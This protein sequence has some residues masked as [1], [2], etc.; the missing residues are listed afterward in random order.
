MK[1]H[2]GALEERTFDLHGRLENGLRAG[3]TGL[4]APSFTPHSREILPR[5]KPTSEFGSDSKTDSFHFHSQGPLLVR[6]PRRRESGTSASSRLASIFLRSL[7]L[8]R[9]EAADV[10][11]EL[12]EPRIVAVTSELNLELQL[13]ALHGKATDG[14]ESADTR[15]APRAVRTAGREFPSLDH[16]SGFLAEDLLVGHRGH[17]EHAAS[18]RVCL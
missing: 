14:T 1:L 10:D 5:Q 16:C 4:A 9:R 13:V 11:V 3:V 7:E 2:D 18:G 6:G 15:P 12:V 17:L 8:P